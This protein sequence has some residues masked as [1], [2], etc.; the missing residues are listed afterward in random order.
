MIFTHNRILFIFPT[1]YTKWLT[2]QTH[3]KQGTS[4]SLHSHEPFFLFHSSTSYYD[5]KTHN[6]TRRHQSWDQ[7]QTSTQTTRKQF[8][9]SYPDCQKIVPKIQSG[10][11]ENSPENSTHIVEKQ[12]RKFLKIPTLGPMILGLKFTVS[13]GLKEN[14]KPLNDL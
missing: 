12:S 2:Y 7:N 8:R 5:I 11:L 3:I 13:H 1:I 10:L 4:W 9:K 6:K 14:P